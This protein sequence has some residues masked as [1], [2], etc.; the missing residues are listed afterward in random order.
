MI[1]SAP[2]PLSCREAEKNWSSKK[3]HTYELTDEL[4]K[5]IEDREIKGTNL[6]TYIILKIQSSFANKQID[7]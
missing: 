6:L 4:G 5:C 7:R 3:F 1:K 2:P